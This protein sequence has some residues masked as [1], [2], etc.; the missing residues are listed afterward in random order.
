LLLAMLLLRPS[1]RPQRVS[2]KLSK[3]LF[4]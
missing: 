3:K 1:A 4:G 2:T